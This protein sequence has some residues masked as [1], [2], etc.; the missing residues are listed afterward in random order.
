ML[1]GYF[2]THICSKYLNTKSYISC[3][4]ITL[5]QICMSMYLYLLSLSMLH[6]LGWFKKKLNALGSCF[7]DVLMEF[8]MFYTGPIEL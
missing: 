5:F 8:Y 3:I 6:S 2:F 7:E 4:F 1:F